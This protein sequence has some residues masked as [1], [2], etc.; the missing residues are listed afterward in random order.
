MYQVAPWI[1]FI[2]ALTTGFLTSCLGLILVNVRPGLKKLFIVALLFALAG[3]VVRSHSLL[4]ASHFIIL[5]CILIVLIKFAWRISFFQAFVSTLLG[6]L[7]LGLMEALTSPIIVNIFSLQ[8]LAPA[9]NSFI[10]LVM[11]L[12]QIILGL[13]F[14]CICLKK[15]YFLFDFSN[16]DLL[17]A[18]SPNEK[19]VKQIL[20]LSSIMLFLLLLQLLLN[21]NIL[22]FLPHRD[23]MQLPVKSIAI[24]RNS[25][26]VAA[27]FLMILLIQ[28]LS[29]LLN[30]ESEFM[31]Q[32]AYINT[33]DELYTASRAEA[34]DRL[35]HFQTLYGF[36]QLGNLEETRHY[37]EELMGEMI[38]S[39]QFIET[40]NPA[41]SSL[42][43]IKSGLAT[44]HNIELDINMNSKLDQLELPPHELNRILGNLI[45]NSFDSVMGLDKP[46]RR[47][48]MTLEEDERS[49]L[50]R[51]L[52]P[53]QID[54]ENVFRK[55][56]STKNN[57]HQG[58]GLYIVKKL[59]DKYHGQIT[60]E[61]QASLVVF[62]V[63]LPKSSTKIDNNKSTTTDVQQAVS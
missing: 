45:N 44:A 38:L 14:A 49:Y 11:P 46:F 21:M 54:P 2:Y 32:S 29:I 9:N 31:Q 6:L 17:Y 39:P 27:F 53:G 43:Y 15:K 52:N 22:N 23:F 1:T 12:T 30:K 50:F 55:G 5:A 40:G 51:I 60:V 8:S 4:L 10:V 13:F 35:N 56:F 47:V 48:Q 24:I 7:A 34:H 58:L 25:T 62:T 63:S 26:M 41:L 19:R 28:Q 36:V 33:L 59:V 61:N 57:Q 3:V 20:V 42:L 16:W 37:L 18:A